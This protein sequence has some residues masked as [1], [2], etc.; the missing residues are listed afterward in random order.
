ML[1]QTCQPACADV[2]ASMRSTYRPLWASQTCYEREMHA[3]LAVAAVEAPVVP[4][5]VVKPCTGVHAAMPA[6]SCS[7]VV[8]GGELPRVVFDI[9]REGPCRMRW[10]QGRRRRPLWSKQPGRP[11][12]AC[13]AAPLGVGASL[14]LLDASSDGLGGCPAAD[15]RRIR[16][17]MSRELQVATA[18]SQRSRPA[19]S[20]PTNSPGSRSPSKGPA[21]GAGIVQQ[22]TAA[23]PALTRLAAQV[24]FQQQLAAEGGARQHALPLH[25]PAGAA[26]R[27]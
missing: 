18:A 22:S 19:V 6:C 23:A 12:P 16:S 8:A 14:A 7:G 13:Q 3:C 26:R 17:S 4:F 9:V 2:S 11:T 20:T 24:F 10:E 15:L 25:A 21:Q 27:R 5:I 1:A